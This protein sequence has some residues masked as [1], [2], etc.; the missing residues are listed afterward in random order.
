MSLKDKN[1][2]I[3]TKSR[4]RME[5]KEISEQGEFIGLLSPYGNVDQ[6][7]DIVEKGAYA[8]T[9][10]AHGN[11]VP[12]LWQHK[13]DSPIGE[14]ELDDRQDGLWAKGKLLLELP[15]AKKAYI[16]IK[17]KVIKGMSIG[18]ET[19]KD[20]V[21]NGIRHLTEIR[22]YEGS[23]VTFPM[24]PLA[25]ITTVK[26]R[27]EK[28]DFVETLDEVQTLG[29]FYQMIQALERSLSET[30]WIGELSREEKIALIETIL[31]QFTESFSEYYPRYLDALYEAYG[32]KMDRMEIEKKIGA[33][34]SASNS[35]KIKTACEKIKSGHDEL[36]ALLE[37]KSGADAATTLSTEP[38]DTKTDPGDSHSAADDLSDL[39]ASLEK[40]R[41]LIPA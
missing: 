30:T 3:K 9:M 31:E 24:N 34:L 29:G 23:I 7:G 6:G 28:G 19:I 35:S 1:N 40:L 13:T 38:A 17:N 15:D 20:T 36:L 27:N 8:R 18:Y 11:Q 25:T 37:D 32:V 10:K 26:S 16:L 22:L 21:E 5:I 41:A 14:L 33:S 2:E 12:L 4:M 39:A